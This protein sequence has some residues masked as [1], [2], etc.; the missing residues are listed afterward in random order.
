MLLIDIVGI[1]MLASLSLMLIYD[2]YKSQKLLNEVTMYVKIKEKTLKDAQTQTESEMF[3]EMKEIT[4]TKEIEEINDF[5]EYYEV[6][7]DTE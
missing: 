1:S 3:I 5:N 6:L 4:P 2:V 7:H